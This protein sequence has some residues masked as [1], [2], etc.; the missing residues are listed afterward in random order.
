MA[1]SS[2][3]TN[4]DAHFKK[5]D[6]AFLGHPKPLQGLFFVE[7]WERF[8]YYGIRPLLV[9]FMTTAIVS[10]GFGFDDTTAAAIYGI[11]SGMMYLV[12]LAGGWL[13]DNWLGQERSLWW[14]C[15][16][17]ALGHLAIGM[18]ALP[19]LGMTMFF[20]GLILL[21]LGT[22][23]FKTCIAVMVGSLY[24]DKDDRRDSGFTVFYMSIN[25]GAMVAPI[26][27][28]YFVDKGQWHTGFTIGGIGML[29]AL[30][31]YRFVAKKYL[32]KFANSKGMSVSWDKPSRRVAHVGKVVFAFLVA[33]CGLVVMVSTGV[34]TINAVAIRDAM[35]YLIIGALFAFFG[36][37]FLSS[38][39]VKAEKMRL[40]VCF[41]LIVGASLF[42]SSFEQQP[43]SFNLFAERYTD[44]S[45]G[46][47]NIPTVWFQSLNPI[48][49]LLFAPLVSMLWIKL[50][51]RHKNPNSM[52]KF[53]LGM[54]LA[55]VAFAI[56]IMASKMIVAGS[57]SVSM[58]WLVSSLLFL[59]IAE[60]CISPVGMSSMT[61][62][63]PQGMQG[64]MMGLWYTSISLGG[65]IGSI[66]GGYVSAE[67]IGDLPKLFTALTV[68]LVV[69]GVL[70]LVLA[71][72][73]TNMLSQTDKDA[74]V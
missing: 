15:I 4:A 6:K 54:L 56:M 65:L 34:L 48:F 70:L 10:G 9:L 57:A 36:W 60:L 29:I 1:N 71:K 38:R 21:V 59:T 66:S 8:S 42:W 62:L 17:M 51:K 16:I 45:L 7:M 18:S 31:V 72:P 20:V 40:L 43:A 47:F 49:I 30:L 55:S 64:V 24:D 23:L 22:G 63:A 46:G 5:L 69:C 35:T 44:R 53:A 58:M 61:K 68:F 26:A 41:F 25:L 19:M 50:G 73:I 37:A 11:F 3:D 74:T 28:G 32:T 67:T 27:T 52:T 12:P 14:G 2:A 33:L 13:A 39:F